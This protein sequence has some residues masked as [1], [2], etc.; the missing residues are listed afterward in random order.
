MPRPRKTRFVEGDAPVQYFKPMGVSLMD[1]S[2][3]VLSLDGLEALR[4]ADVEGVDQT[5][6]AQRMGISRPTFSRLLAEARKAVSTALTQG[7]AI[8]V[9]G[10]PV[11]VMPREWAM[12]HHH[13]HCLRRRH[14]WFQRDEED[15]AAEDTPKEK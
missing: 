5:E 7:L 12:H 8:R 6:A 15:E 4:L 3:V 14:R 2:E 13:P 1:L 10:G 11:E 9:G